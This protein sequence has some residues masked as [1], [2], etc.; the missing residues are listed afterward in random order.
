MPARKAILI[1]LDM[2]R[3]DHLGCYGYPRETSPNIDAFAKEGTLFE[4]CTSSFCCTVPS[5]TGML[6]G[7]SPLNHG[8]I[9]NAWDAPNIRREWLDDEMPTLAEWKQSVAD[10]PSAPDPLMD[11]SRWGIQKDSSLIN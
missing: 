2:L 4:D 1:A 11:A 10:D 6:T 3:S 9:L 7:K 5:F 8:I